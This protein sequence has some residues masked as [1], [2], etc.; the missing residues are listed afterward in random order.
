MTL[1]WHVRRQVPYILG[2]YAF[3]IL[4]FYCFLLVTGDVGTCWCR[5]RRIRHRGA[6][7]AR[8]RPH[9]RRQRGPSICHVPVTYYRRHHRGHRFEGSARRHPCGGLLHFC[10]GRSPRILVS[11]G[12]LRRDPAASLTMVKGLLPQRRALGSDPAEPVCW[13]P[14]MNTL[15]LIPSS[16]SP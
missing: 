1:F 3:Q 16:P 13:Q 12:I 11:G 8:S 15:S 2:I 7:R 4:T 5:S 6:M 9:L 14:E 10:N